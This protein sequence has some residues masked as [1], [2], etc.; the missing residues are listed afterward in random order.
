[1]GWI[2]L[3]LLHRTEDGPGSG[4]DSPEQKTD[5]AMGWIPQNRRWIWQWVGFPRTEDG[6]CSGLDSPEQKTDLAVGWIP[7]ILLHRTE[8]GPQAICSSCIY[9]SGDRSLGG[10]RF[11]L[12][13]TVQVITFNS[14]NGTG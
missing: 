7:L 12:L 1:M 11:L 8:D 5:L 13:G 6:P 14:G 3:I 10:G 2:P 9:H 4:L